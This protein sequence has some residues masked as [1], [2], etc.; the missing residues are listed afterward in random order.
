MVRFMRALVIAV[1]ASSC[2]PSTYA[3]VRQVSTIEQ[4]RQEL[5]GEQPSITQYPPNAEAWYFGKNECVLFIDG[6]LR[7]SKSTFKTEDDQSVAD[8]KQTQVVCSPSMV[9][10]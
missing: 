1:F 10:P 8:W 7:F 3:R 4:A 5:R 6:V 9:S 2:V